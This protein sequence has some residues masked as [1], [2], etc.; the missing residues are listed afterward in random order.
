MARRKFRRTSSPFQTRICARPSCVRRTQMQVSSSF[1]NAL[2]SYLQT[3]M[4]ARGGTM[5]V[6]SRSVSV[7]QLRSSRPSVRGETRC[8]FPQILQQL[9]PHQRRHLFPFVVLALEPGGPERGAP[10]RGRFGVPDPED[11]VAT[12]TVGCRVGVL[13]EWGRKAEPKQGPKSNLFF[14]N[15]AYRKRIHLFAIKLE[16]WVDL[17]LGHPEARS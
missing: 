1:V 7:F 14:G 3:P 8:E 12:P 16:P 11:A 9:M 2:S 10:K 4:C 6:S 13:Q 17:K 15:I 5:P